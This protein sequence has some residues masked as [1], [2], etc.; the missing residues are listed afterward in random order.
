M[1]KALSLARF[2]LYTMRCRASLELTGDSE[3]SLMLGLIFEN[4]IKSVQNFAT[5]WNIHCFAND[6]FFLWRDLSRQRKGVFSL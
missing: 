5:L 3:E 6:E 1:P 4:L 2:A